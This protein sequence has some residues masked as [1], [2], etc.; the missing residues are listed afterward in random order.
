MYPF[1]VRLQGSSTES[2]IPLQLRTGRYV[3]VAIMLCIDPAFGGAGGSRLT[4]GR[5]LLVGPNE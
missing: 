4:T 3:M 1:P 5:H 2:L